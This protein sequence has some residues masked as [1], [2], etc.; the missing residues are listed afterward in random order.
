MAHH[1]EGIEGGEAKVEIG[2][3]HGR[4][5]LVLGL[6]GAWLRG[7]QCHRLI[8]EIDSCQGPSPGT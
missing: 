3:D 5:I 8:T 6:Q 4:V 2:G 7:F 1:G